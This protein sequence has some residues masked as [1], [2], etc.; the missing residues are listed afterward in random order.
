[1]TTTVSRPTL[2]LLPGLDG[3]GKLFSGFVRALGADID[4]QIV[5][6]PVD[7]PLGYAELETLVRATLP[8]DRR[9]VVLG[10]SFSGP[11]AIQIGA[12]PPA[13]LAG[14]VDVGITGSGAGPCP[15]EPSHGRSLGGCDSA[16]HR[17]AARRE[18]ERGAVARTIANSGAASAARSRHT[19][20]GDAMDSQDRASCAVGRGRRTSLIAANA[21]GGMCG[22]GDPICARSHPVNQDC[23]NCL[24]IRSIIVS[25]TTLSITSICDSSTKSIVSD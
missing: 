19:P 5:S 6:Y 2:I 10:E 17:R 16:P 12:N 9:F 24:K 11:I 1:M 23:L 14:A 18:R 4:A 15:V 25:L 7:Q 3:T 13:G 21:S 8:A 20:V 22:R